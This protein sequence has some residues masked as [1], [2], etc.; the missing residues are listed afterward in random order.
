MPI[1]HHPPRTPNGRGG[2]DQRPGDGLFVVPLLKMDHWNVVGLGVGVD[3]LDV[4]VTDT[5]ERR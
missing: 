4:A 3:R 1:K 2:V 5:A